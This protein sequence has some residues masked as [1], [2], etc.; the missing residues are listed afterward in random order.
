MNMLQAFAL[1]KGASAASGD[2]GGD[3]SAIIAEWK[4]FKERMER[5]IALQETA[6]GLLRE[7][8]AQGAVASKGENI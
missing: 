4:G 3:L 6:N 2:G 7:L 1:M 5:L 8:I